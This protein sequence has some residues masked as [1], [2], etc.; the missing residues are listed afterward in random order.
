MGGT[1]PEDKRI[2]AE[3]EEKP[4]KYKE[5]EKKRIKP[6]EEK[7]EQRAEE[8]KKEEEPWTH[9]NGM[10]PPPCHSRSSRTI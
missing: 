7:E 5:E 9:Y 1:A 3:K 4:F 10:A 8:E 2:Q 6:E